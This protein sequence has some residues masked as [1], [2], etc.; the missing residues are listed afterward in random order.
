MMRRYRWTAPARR[1]L[2]LMLVCALLTALM[3]LPVTAAVEGDSPVTVSYALHKRNAQTWQPTYS[4]DLNDIRGITSAYTDGWSFYGWSDRLSPTKTMFYQYNNAYVRMDMNVLGAWA[5]IQIHMPQAGRYAMDMAYKKY[6]TGGAANIYLIPIPQDGQTVESL[7]TDARKVGSFESLDAEAAKVAD[8]AAQFEGVDVPAEGDYL[9]VF[10]QTRIDGGR[11]LMLSDIVFTGA[12][13]ETPEVTASLPAQFVEVG[14][15]AEIKLTDA[16]G[17]PVSPGGYTITSSDPT[18]ATVSGGSV[19]GVSIGRATLTIS[20]AAGESTLEIPVVGE[21]L[22]TRDG[23]E[24]GSFA[25][26]AAYGSALG[27]KFWNVYQSDKDG[28]MDGDNYSFEMVKGE[29]AVSA[30]TNLLKLSSSGLPSDPAKTKMLFSLRSAATEPSAGKQWGGILAESGK[31]YELS[32]WAKAGADTQSLH[33]AWSVRTYYYAKNTGGTYTMFQNA[34][35]TT[36]VIPWKGVSGAPDWTYF[37]TVPI[38][39]DALTDYTVLLQPRI[40]GNKPVASGGWIGDIYFADFSMHEVQYDKLDFTA[41]EDVSALEAGAVV[42]TGVRHLSTTGQEIAY[43]AVAS[44]TDKGVPTT[45]EAAIP[46]AYQSLNESVATVAAD[47]AITAVSSGTAIIRASATVGG[48]TRTG[49]IVVTVAGGAEETK[50]SVSAQACP[51]LQEGGSATAALTVTRSDG[52]AVDFSKAQVSFTYGQQGIVTASAVQDAQGI[53]VK[54]DAQS[55]GS[56]QVLVTVEE[57]DGVQGSCTIPVTV[58]RAQT[59]ATLSVS[60]QE[61][62]SVQSGADAAV[63]LTITRSDGQAVDYTAATVTTS[64]NPQGIAEAVTIKEA[65]GIRLQITGKAAGSAELTV[66]VDCGSGL[67]DSCKIAVDVAQ[68]DEIHASLPARFV[69]VGQSAQ[70]KLTDAAGNPVSAEGYTVTSQNPDIAT[71]DGTTVTG[72]AIGRAEIRITGPMETTLTAPVVGENLLVRE[73]LNNGEFESGAAFGSAASD[74]F[75]QIVN[76]KS[77]GYMFGSNYSWEIFQGESATQEQT[78]VLKLSSSGLPEDPGDTNMQFSFRSG[79]KERAA[80]AS[81]ARWLCRGQNV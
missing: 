55:A 74:K 53:A 15:S 72:R 70:I 80:T 71:V 38:S 23:V 11:Y 28:Y 17:N 7:L 27:S 29:S 63:P 12:A 2:S 45:K 9:L 43:Q 59:S 60:A 75:W 35:N 78:N 37:A 68:K 5:A 49:E 10:E 30:E 62:V 18:V 54:I 6:K 69:E 50:L 65:A 22:L 4:D 32:G 21:N 33:D 16:A 44:V 24:N 13:F 20:G 39:N 46:V 19:T 26:G 47:G 25:G 36:Q 57:A 1:L 73:G 64:W 77:G 56:T 52:Q 76:Q 48:I 79:D 51:E 61:K 40:E 41:A 14:R 67:K 34:T 81:W 31:L 58:T 3:P 66:T 42:A 8:A